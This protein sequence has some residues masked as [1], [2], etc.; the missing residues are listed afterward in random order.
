MIRPFP[1]ASADELRILIP[2]GAQ[3]IGIVTNNFHIF[4]SLAI[5]RAEGLENI[6]G[7]PV[8]TSLLSYP[9]YMMREFIGVA[10]DFVRGNLAF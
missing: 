7:V 4:R 9:H 3:N 5:A 1:N 8:P 6:S 2:E 10:W